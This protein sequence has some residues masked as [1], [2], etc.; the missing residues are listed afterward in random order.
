MSLHVGISIL[1]SPISSDGSKF[2]DQISYARGLLKHYVSEYRRIYGPQNLIYC[3]HVLIHLPDDVEFY[4]KP[5]SYTV[6]VVFL[7]KII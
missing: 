6:T 5:L 3:V 4:R 1:V 2:K 7:L